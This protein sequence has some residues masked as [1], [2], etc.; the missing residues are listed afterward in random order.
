MKSITI[1]AVVASLFAATP[2]TKITYEKSV[3]I[4]VLEPSDIASSSDGKYYAV[5]DNGYLA[6][7]DENMNL[8]RKSDFIGLDFEGVYCDEKYVYI[9]DESLRKITVL[10][11]QNLKP[12]RSNT[13]VYSGGRN[14]G[15]ESL[16]Y[17]PITKR[18][19]TIT[20]KNPTMIVELDENFVKLNEVPLKIARDISSATYHDGKLYVLSD[21]DETVFCLN[22]D[23]YSVIGKW[24]INILNPE[25]IT[26]N[27]DGK[28][29]ICSDD[30]HHAY[31]FNLPTITQ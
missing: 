24:K 9:M 21:E 19:I 11:K 15:F 2:I 27:K 29:V 7:L 3:N 30:M 20:E 22:P 13:I 23:N 12:V 26:F 17:N 14:Q 31:F 25:G 28:M 10:D 1:F 16:T 5:S 4:P 18:F 6:E 8:L